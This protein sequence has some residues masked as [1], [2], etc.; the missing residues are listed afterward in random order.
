MR[1]LQKSIAK[2]LREKAFP[3]KNCIW[4]YKEPSEISK[5]IFKFKNI[6]V[7]ETSRLVRKLKRNKSAGVDNL[8]P[9]YLKDIFDSI[10][11]PFTHILNLS[12]ENGEVPYDFKIA[13]ITPLFKSGSTKELGN[14]RPI[15]VLPI[16]SKILEKIVHKQLI[17]YLEKNHMLSNSQ[18][19]FRPGRSTEQAVTSL[20]DHI[21]KEMDKGNYTGILYIDLSKAFDTISHG[22]VLSKLRSFGIIGTPKEWFI[23]YLFNR[24]QSVYYDGVMSD[25][26]PIYC[27]VPQGSILGPLLF[28]LHL[29]DVSEVIHHAKILKYADDTALLVS[30]KDVK[31]IE[32]LLN[33]DF[34]NICHWLEE[35]DLI[36]NMKKGKTE[37]MIFGTNPRLK[38]LSNPPINLSYRNVPVFY[39]TTYTYL[40]VLLNSTLNLSEHLTK[41]FRKSAGRL[42]LLRRIRFAINSDTAAKIYNAMIIPLIT[43]C[44]M[45]TTPTIIE[46][47]KR[48]L[49]ILE[50]RAQ[51][52]IGKNTILPDVTNIMK[53]RCCVQVFRSINEDICESLRNYFELT[54][55]RSNRSKGKTIRLPRIRIETARHSF[56]FYGAKIF[57]SLPAEVR[58]ADDLKDFKKGLHQF[59]T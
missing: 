51:R 21:R 55:I 37:F 50:D 43:Y 7:A 40:G 45:A 44:P 11:L 49:N 36:I 20:T 2:T 9:G 31:V 26:Q 18:F 56:Y 54:D 8:P 46:K 14:Y 53:K 16:M 1:F 39:T 22:T 27:G 15:S 32:T 17:D 38:K 12:L 34:S 5:T 52:I 58:N 25:Y 6:S 24:R 59:L 47:Q 3:L 30:H 29:N 4:S 35:N 19:G 48:Q 33:T 28:L 42:R 57:N 10:A 13:K 23:N 41:S